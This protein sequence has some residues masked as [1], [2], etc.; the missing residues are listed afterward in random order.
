[1]TDGS[2]VGAVVDDHAARLVAGASTVALCLDFDGT[3]APIVDDPEQARPLPGVVD[4]LGT[5]A[6]R[7]A[8]VAVVSGRPASYLAEHAAA[9]GVRYLGMY[10][11]QE[12]RDPRDAVLKRLDDVPAVIR[13]RAGM[14]GGAGSSRSSSAK[15]VR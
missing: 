4:L 13:L 12:I 15:G 5:L 3:L 8:A 10:G 2:S 7:F 1:V 14:P 11:L 6:A 9:A